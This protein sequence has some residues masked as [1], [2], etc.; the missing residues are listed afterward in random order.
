MSLKNIYNPL[1]KYGLQRV[2][3]DSEW[4]V[5]ADALVIDKLSQNYIADAS[6]PENIKI[7]DI[8]RSGLQFVLPTSLSSDKYI[9]IYIDKASS[10]G[11][12]VNDGVSI[13]PFNA[14]THVECYY[15]ASLGSW[16]VTY[17]Q[18]KQQTLVC[19][20]ADYKMISAQQGGGD[21]GYW[22]HVGKLKTT[23]PS[24]ANHVIAFKIFSEQGYGHSGKCVYAEAFY[25]LN[26]IGGIFFCTTCESRGKSGSTIVNDW[27]RPEHIVSV[28]TGT[29]RGANYTSDIW[30]KLPND[31]AVYFA[32][33]MYGGAGVNK[34]SWASN[35]WNGYQE[36]KPAQPTGSNVYVCEDKTIPADVLRAETQGF[37]MDILLEVLASQN[38]QLIVQ[39]TQTTNLQTSMMLD[40][41]QASLQARR[42][43]RLV[44]DDYVLAT[45]D[46]EAE[47]NVESGGR[48]NVNASEL[49]NVLAADMQFNGRTVPT[50][51]RSFADGDT[52]V[53]EDSAHFYA[54]DSISSL[55]VTGVYNPLLPNEHITFAI[56]FVTAASGAVSVTFPA[57]YK[58]TSAPVFGNNERWEI[59]MKDNYV[60]WTKYDL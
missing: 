36:F 7:N 44:R 27:F 13:I 42:I 23:Y 5:P 3:D 19:T 15:S 9:N 52:I 25:N 35:T 50:L 28:T 45:E 29:R 56:S 32:I 34:W 14:N 59:A 60:V 22:Y 12:Y 8:T 57:E 26:T 30:I 38:I 16:S 33:E 21:S 10:N 37:P 51:L 17:E 47:F 54:S 6:T 43:R 40:D 46:G 11:L 53:A 4:V 24:Y 41:E 31:T 48:I 55:T 2:T 1:L 18:P 58:F 20:F 49:F 39:S